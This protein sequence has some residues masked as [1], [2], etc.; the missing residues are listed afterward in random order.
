MSQSLYSF[1]GQ[2]GPINE[3]EVDD[4]EV[5]SVI[6]A[7]EYEYWNPRFSIMLHE[8]EFA[9][10]D[11]RMARQLGVRYVYLWLPADRHTF[12]DL[13]KVKGRIESYGLEL[14]NVL[15]GV[16]AKNASIH[17]GLADRDEAISKF[18]EFL[19]WLSELGLKR[20]TFTWE[21]DAV[22]S[23]GRGTD[24]GCEAR[25][26][27]VRK[28][29]HL[30][31]RHGR[32]YTREELWE[33]FKYFMGE[34]M[35][36]AERLGIRLALHPND[37]PVA[38][39]IAGVPALIHSVDDYRRAFE[40]AGSGALG[41]EFCCGC[42][43]E[44]G[45]EFGELVGNLSEFVEAGRVEILHMRNVSS[46][47]PKFTEC[48]LDDGYFDMYEVFRELARKNY[49]GTITLDHTPTMADGPKNYA[50][51]AYAVGYMRGMTARANAELGRRACE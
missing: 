49:K 28:L 14:H 8:Y 48:F 47:L 15:S 24:R 42:W 46:T 18:K 3:A 26:V 27:D 22:W 39:A 29:E 11:A 50:A 35:P 43:L 5:E 37:P 30:P 21:P 4:Q 41:M 10:A 6:E 16:V 34:I 32:E 45:G 25:V 31:L 17:L 19:G 12:E 7:S 44:G 9:E 23:S 38:F 1:A 33:N 2:Y 36:V 20:T 40:V 13:K 51:T